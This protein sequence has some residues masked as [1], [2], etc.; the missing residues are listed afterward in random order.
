ML[1]D[2]DRTLSAGNGGRLRA[3]L[4]R[5]DRLIPAGASYAATSAVRSDNA[6]YYLYPRTRVA[7]GFD[8]SSLKRSGVRWVIVTPDAVPASLRG[9]GRW[10]RVVVSSS[11]GRLIEV[12]G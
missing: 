6:R 12:T 3:L 8:R 10:Y 2:A 4:I 7:T 5:A 1:R 11:A 9:D